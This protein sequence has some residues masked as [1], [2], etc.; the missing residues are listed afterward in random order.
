MR[1]LG[2][3]NVTALY[4][5]EKD[6]KA[7][8]GRDAKHVAKLLG[9]K[10]KI[11]DISHLLKLMGVY[12]LFPMNLLRNLPSKRVQGSIIKNSQKVLEIIKKEDPLI[13]SRRGS[14]NKF[15]RHGNAYANSKHRQR[16]VIL[17]FFAEKE[18]LMSVGGANQT[19]YL[20]GFFTKFGIDAIADIMPILPLFKVQVRQLASW[21]GIPNHI[22]N[23]EADPDIIPGFTDKGKLFKDELTL[24]LA[25]YGLL[26][27]YPIKKICEDLDID[28]G[29]IEK[30]IKL[31]KASKHM[32]EAPY[33]PKLLTELKKK[34]V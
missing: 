3:N 19:E 6:T 1:A 2:T 13:E 30:V 34:D 15:T 29:Y 17:N 33:I 5:P 23:K 25:L 24:D 8:H 31:M 18:N 16:M 26:N 20:T 28:T 22:V 11:I 21:L 32:R 7:K 14:S 10:F 4:M 12:D 27:Q 9:I